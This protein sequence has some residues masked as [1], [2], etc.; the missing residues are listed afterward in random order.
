M[1]KTMSKNNKRHRLGQNYLVDLGVLSEVM[2][3]ISPSES[4]SW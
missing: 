1:R 3:A 4:K 2:T